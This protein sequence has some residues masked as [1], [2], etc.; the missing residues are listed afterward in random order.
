MANTGGAGPN[1]PSTLLM[2]VPRSHSSCPVWRWPFHRGVVSANSP[3]SVGLICENAGGEDPFG[4]RGN[5]AGDWISSG[6]AAIRKVIEY[7][8]K[9]RHG[10]AC[11]GALCALE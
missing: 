11:L 5:Y 8:V 7:H 2:S 9:Y 1:S 4:R 6:L 3:T 10:L